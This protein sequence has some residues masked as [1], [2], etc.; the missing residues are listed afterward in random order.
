MKP[1]YVCALVKPQLV[2]LFSVIP[3]GPNGPKELGT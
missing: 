3:T 1:Q 2:A